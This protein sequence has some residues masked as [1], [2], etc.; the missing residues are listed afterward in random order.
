[1]LVSG[2]KLAVAIRSLVNDR[3]LQFECAKVLHEALLIPLSLNGSKPM[4]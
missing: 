2:K 1:M 4:L 3:D